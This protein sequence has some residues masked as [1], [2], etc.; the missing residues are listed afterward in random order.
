MAIYF[1]GYLS[2][3]RNKLG[4]AVGR[5]WRTLDVLSVYNGRPRNPRTAA[6][7]AQRSKFGFIAGIARQF[8]A[9][10]ELGF[11]PL[12]DG[13][14]IPQRSMFIKKNIE[15]V[16]MTDPTTP[17]I[18]TS[19]IVI[20]EGALPEADFGNPSF[21]D[22]LSVKV[23]MTDTSDLPGASVQDKVFIF[24]WDREANAGIL[25]APKEREAASIEVTV[26]T[27]W[28]GHRVYV[29]G[30]TVGG[31]GETKGMVSNS[32]FLGSGSIS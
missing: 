13:T 19:S 21:S 14:P 8:A 30:F 11:K 32:R 31:N 4:N 18:D 22:P 9:A 17:T 10:A 5:K 26:P 3:I 23:P 29:Y 28:N 15:S 27:I 1:A 25:S 12:C 20:A 16:D 24:V 6:Q 7:Q 2:P